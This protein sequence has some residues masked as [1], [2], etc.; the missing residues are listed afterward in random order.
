[1][2]IAKS[3]AFTQKT[4]AP[5]AANDLIYFRLDATVRTWSNKF[6]KSDSWV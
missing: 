6:V 3:D 5:S 2:S 1:M 4:L